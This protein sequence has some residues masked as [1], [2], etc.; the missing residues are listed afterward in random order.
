MRA[1]LR[2]R[3]ILVCLL[4]CFSIWQ[5]PARLVGVLLP[6][7]L[8]LAAFS[9]SFW[10][11][12]AARGVWRLDDGALILGRVNWHLSPLSLVLLRPT[13]TIEVAWGGQQLTGAFTRNLSGTVVIK[14]FYARFDSGL[15]R[16]FLP[17]Y[18][19]GRAIADFSEIAVAS[20]KLLALDGKLLW[21]NAVWAAAAG[22]VPLGD[23]QLRLSNDNNK[24][25]GQVTTLLGTLIVTGD[26]VVAENNYEIDLDL[27]GPATTDPELS[28]AL[29]L[30]AAPT[31]TGFDMVIEG[32]F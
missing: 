12:E 23:Y 27:S 30:L 32:S 13:V 20:D 24:V 9:G 25:Q 17:L 3:L 8:M 6:E 1:S 26:V 10:T 28:G 18:I 4:I 15:I 29:Q 16:Q 11:G 31:P 21:K 5:A 19:G 7:R 22:D 14:N 2:V